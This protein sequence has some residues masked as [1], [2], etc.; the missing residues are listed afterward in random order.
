MPI[1]GEEHTYS[2]AHESEMDALVQRVTARMRATFLT[3]VAF[4]IALGGLMS[5]LLVN[6]L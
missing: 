4:G 5:V 6:L 3:G 1:N 2:E